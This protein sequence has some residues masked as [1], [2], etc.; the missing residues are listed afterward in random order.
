MSVEEYW[1]GKGIDIDEIWI[2]FDKG[3]GYIQKVSES[4]LHR[5]RL[6][7]TNYPVELPLF[8]FEAIFKTVKATFHDVKLE[9]LTPDAYNE[10][11][12]IFLHRVDRGSGI[13]EFLAQ[14]DPL[15]T[16]IFALGGAVLGY[17][18]LL[19]LDQE[20]DEKRFDFMRR[21]FP[22][23]NIVDVQAYIKAQTTFSRRR[24]LNRLIDQGLKKV[25]LSKTKHTSEEDAHMV[26][27]ETIMSLEQP[28]EASSNR[29]E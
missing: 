8:N 1:I 9:C 4:S 3:S 18:K 2:D 21:N 22:D 14:F 11:T 19:T 23:A 16:W 29:I 13:F 20:F 10:A 7:F 26:D 5:M 27:M 6:T 15:M 25:E 24:V 28:N 12:P 17:K